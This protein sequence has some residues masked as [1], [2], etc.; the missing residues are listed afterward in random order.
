[1]S[2][3]KHDLQTLVSETALKQVS[4]R[5]K[6]NQELLEYV[7]QFP[8]NTLAEKIYLATT[9]ESPVCVRGKP[10]KFRSL[11]QGYG[12]CGRSRDCECAR[13]SVST[14]V[15]T[16]KSQYTQDQK[17]EISKKTKNTNLNRY[18]VENAGQT[19]SAR[20]R[21]K[22]T[23]TN[24]PR[25]QEIVNQTKNTK[26]AKHGDKNYNNPEKIKTTFRTKGMDYWQERFADKD[27]ETLF[28]KT[29]M[30]KLFDTM[31][32]ADIAD[33]CNVHVQ[34]VFRYLNKHGITQ[35]YKS[36]E[37][38]AIVNFI[39]SLGIVNIFE[40]TRKVLPNRKELDIYLPDYDLAIEYNG[41]YW[42]H[43]DVDHI[44]KSYHKKKSEMCA[45]QGIQLITIFSNFWKSKPEIVKG[46]LR[47][48]LGLAQRKIGARQCTIHSVTTAESKAFLENYHIQGYTPASTRLGLYY[49]NE[50]VALMTFGKQR[51]GMGRSEGAQELVRYASKASVAGGASKLLKYFIENYKPHKIISYSDNEWSRGDLYRKLGFE[52]DT[53]LAPSYWYLRPREERLY[54]RFTF[55][56][57]KLVAKGYDSNL[58][59][60][61]ITRDMGLLKI[62]DCGKKRWVM[63]VT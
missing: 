37:E 50:L 22:E 36:S 18:G 42:H 53:E 40:N 30:Q 60:K 16:A 21:H 29:E 51:V 48:K 61:Q 49:N 44:T 4:T 54:H 35:P 57:Q 59:E 28:S 45:E 58:T 17:S 12:F 27:I 24:N 11:S 15:S 13:D 41:V 38:Q 26:L 10:K 47:N 34:T 46:F 56:K 32:V 55:S 1:M 3:L 52:L 20:Q 39:R 43:D 25:V 23:Y 62:W 63:Q 33:K 31:S 2:T 7:K 8:G 5:V 6:N 9:S 14:R 19:L